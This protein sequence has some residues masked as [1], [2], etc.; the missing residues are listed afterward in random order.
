MVRRWT[1]EQQAAAWEPR[2]TEPWAPRSRA[3]KKM[4]KKAVSIPLPNSPIKETK[5]LPESRPGKTK[6]DK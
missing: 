3:W 4:E 5:V 6:P 2:L 1:D